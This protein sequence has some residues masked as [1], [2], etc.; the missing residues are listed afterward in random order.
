[1][2]LFD[3]YA[4]IAFATEPGNKNP[5]RPVR[6]L[7][8]L[9]QASNDIGELIRLSVDD[10][11]WQHIH[12]ERLYNGEITSEQLFH[13]DTHPPISRFKERRKK[14]QGLFNIGVF[15]L[16]LT[17]EKDTILIYMCVWNGQSYQHVSEVLQT[18]IS[19]QNTSSGLEPPPQEYNPLEGMSPGEDMP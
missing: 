13:E 7:Q 11:C 5:E 1:M 18:I 4:H 12:F 6:T 15:S 2:N 14:F 3:E 19:P 17:V 16:A 9:E 8:E 10:F